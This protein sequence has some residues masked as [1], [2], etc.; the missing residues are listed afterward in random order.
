MDAHTMPTQASAILERLEQTPNEWVP[1]PELVRVSEAYAVH[2]RIAELR[3][4]RGKTI[5]HENR[6]I[7]NSRKLASYYKLIP[8]FRLEP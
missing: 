5:L 3:K 6:S 4:K 2:S 1:M 8:D 7:P